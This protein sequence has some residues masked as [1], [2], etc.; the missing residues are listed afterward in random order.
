MLLHQVQ[1]EIPSSEDPH[2]ETAAHVARSRMADS[3]EYNSTFFLRVPSK[4]LDSEEV[5]IERTI[6]L[7]RKERD[8]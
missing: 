1:N 4:L 2:V 5:R 6:D 3:S 8:I 7:R